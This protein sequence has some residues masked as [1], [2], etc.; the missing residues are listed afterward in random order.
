MEKL[1]EGEINKLGIF[2]FGFILIFLG[3]AFSDVIG[4]QLYLATNLGSLINESVVITASTGQLAQDDVDTVSYF[5]NTTNDT[6]VLL[7]NLINITKAGVIT[8]DPIIGNT[9]YNASYTY[10]GDEYVVGATNR[11]IL[12]LVLIFFVVTVLLG[13]MWILSQTG[14]MEFIK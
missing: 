14:I 8:T 9:T 10:E 3:I 4:D 5:G 2:I 12:S 6:T 11:T 7:D 1:A 13:G